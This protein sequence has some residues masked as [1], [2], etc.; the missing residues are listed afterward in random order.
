MSSMPTGDMAALWHR[1]CVVCR[2]LSHS[3][4]AARQ[5]SAMEATLFIFYSDHI[6]TILKT[7]RWTSTPPPNMFLIR[8]TVVF[9]NVVSRRYSVLL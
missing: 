8:M 1:I 2:L 4:Y 6:L 3:G 5:K 7:T 9:I